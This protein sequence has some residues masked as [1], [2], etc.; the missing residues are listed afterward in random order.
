[1]RLSVLLV[2]LCLGVV[3]PESGLAQS[4]QQPATAPDPALLKVARETVAQMQGDRTATLSSMS[5]PLVG[6]MQQI[7][8]KEPEKAQVLVQEV[9][10]PTL[11]AHYDDLLDIQARGFATVLG[12]DDLQ[13]IAA[14]YATPA[15]KHLAAAQPQLAQIQLAGMQQWMQSVMPEIQGK[16]TK[17]IQAHGWAPGGQAKPR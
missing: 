4:A 6:M 1:M 8:I 14:F 12:K 10:M 9:V 7:G 11:T 2:G 16:L 13:A 3:L 15:G 17:A 5:A